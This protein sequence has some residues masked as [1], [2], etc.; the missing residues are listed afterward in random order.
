MRSKFIGVVPSILIREQREQSRAEQSRRETEDGR[1]ETGES[2]EQRA[3]TGKMMSN[4]RDERHET[5]CACTDT[6]LPVR[7]AGQPRPRCCR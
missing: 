4:E 7:C 6:N 3:E 5:T 2:R 1:R